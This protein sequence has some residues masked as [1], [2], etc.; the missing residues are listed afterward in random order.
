MSGASSTRLA[1]GPV[2]QPDPPSPRVTRVPIAA[3]RTAPW[4]P[5]VAGLNEDHARSLA[6]CDGELP[7]I[8]VRRSMHVIDGAHRVRAAQLRG[9]NDIDAIVVDDSESEAFIRSV[10]ANSRHGLPLTL[11]DRKQ[12]AAR[13]LRI[14]PD[15]SDRA[16]A[17][18]AG[19]SGKTVGALR[20]SIDDLPQLGARVGRDGRVRAISAP[21]DVVPDSRPTTDPPDTGAEPAAPSEPRRAPSRTG[22]SAGSSTLLAFPTHQQP[23]Q[24]LAGLMRDPSLRYTE[25]GRSLLR[26]LHQQSMVTDQPWASLISAVLPHCLPA[27]ITL[28]N[29]YAESWK[30]LGELAEHLMQ[31]S[32]RKVS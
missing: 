10:T 22:E 5:R 27:V 25:A 19:L 23:Q 21:R 12:A 9:R 14:C 30:Q 29:S 17:E 31:C 16:I 8:L 2:P 24:I 6:E 11:R 28:A 13:L 4:Y 26:G 18:L 20:R 3:L 7:P 15:K 1:G 32:D